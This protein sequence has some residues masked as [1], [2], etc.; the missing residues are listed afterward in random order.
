MH[1]RGFAGCPHL[2]LLLLLLQRRLPGQ[3]SWLLLQS[4]W[5]PPLLVLVLV[6]VLLGSRGRRFGAGFGGPVCEEVIKVV[7]CLLVQPL[8]LQRHNAQATVP[9]GA[10]FRGITV[11][12]AL[13]SQ[14]AEVLQRFGR[15]C[16]GALQQPP[17]F[18]VPPAPS[19]GPQL[20]F[21]SFPAPSTP[22]TIFPQISLTAHI[23]PA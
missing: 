12:T 20:A 16:P 21:T 5:P 6:L 22:F 14:S 11:M 18:H 1:L 3:L 4:L 10:C 2:L 8:F 17:G 15:A 13:L 9:N 7:Q 23:L 19:S